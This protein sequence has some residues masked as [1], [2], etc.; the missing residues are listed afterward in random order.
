MNKER[1]TSLPKSSDEILSQHTR[2]IHQ[3]WPGPFLHVSTFLPGC[4]KIK[5]RDPR[6]RQHTNTH[7]H[8][9]R[10]RT[11]LNYWLGENRDRKGE[12]RQIKKK[13]K[14]AID[15]SLRQWSWLTKHWTRGRLTKKN[16]GKNRKNKKNATMLWPECKPVPVRIQY[17]NKSISRKTKMKIKRGETRVTTGPRG[18]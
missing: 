7:T 9:Q 2:G 3:D 6:H 17:V 13:G 11:I 15:L 16:D 18:A 4:S 10:T 5:Y 12:K 14:I 1:P 8:T